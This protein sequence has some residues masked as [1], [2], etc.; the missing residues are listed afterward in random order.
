MKFI[1]T[2]K[3]ENGKVHN[4][5]LHKLRAQNTINHFFCF[6]P[7]FNFEALL[8]ENAETLPGLYKLRVIYSQEIESFTYEPYSPRNVR[9]LKL[10]NCDTIEYN[11]KFEDRSQINELL[12]RRDN[13]DDILI[14]KNGLITDTSYS[15]ILFLENKKLFTPASCL[16]KGVKR[17][18]FINCKHAIERDLKVEDLKHVDDVFLINSMIEPLRIEYIR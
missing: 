1:E 6:K 3:V 9:S 5:E 18:S 15:N 8:P 16:L 13:C 14:V 11:Y 7:E 17:Q 12:K 4:L 10:I 2:I